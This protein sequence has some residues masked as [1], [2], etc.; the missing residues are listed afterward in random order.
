MLLDTARS[1][2]TH[3]RYALTATRFL[4]ALIRRDQ[5]GRTGYLSAISVAECPGFIS[6][7]LRPDVARYMATQ[8]ISDLPN[9]RTHSMLA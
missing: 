6:Q 2:S 9:Q 4:R 3:W 7:P 8:L 5:V 1:P